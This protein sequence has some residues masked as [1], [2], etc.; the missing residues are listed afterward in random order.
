MLD[1]SVSSDAVAIPVLLSIIM[2]WNGYGIIILRIERRD[3]LLLFIA[4]AKALL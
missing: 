4:L 1:S 3:V 2:S